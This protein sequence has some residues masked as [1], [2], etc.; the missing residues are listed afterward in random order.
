MPVGQISH[1]CSDQLP[2]AS[3][4]SQ[5]LPGH[6]KPKIHVL[7]R[8][9][10]CAQQIQH[11]QD[12]L[13][14]LHVSCQA[15]QRMC[16]YFCPGKSCMEAWQPH[17]RD[18]YPYYPKEQALSLWISLG[19]GDVP[20]FQFQDEDLSCGVKPTCIRVQ[21]EEQI[22]FPELQV[23]SLGTVTSSCLEARCTC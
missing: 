16:T 22:Y 1:P 8:W 2:G 14:S 19:E 5:M 23:S 12:V 6:V 20:Y 7:A 3:T 18:F 11:L 10:L 15:V 21:P 4:V 17:P 13:D 9:S